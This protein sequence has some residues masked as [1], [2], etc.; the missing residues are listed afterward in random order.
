MVQMASIQW[1]SVAAMAMLTTGCA[2]MHNAQAHEGRGQGAPSDE[3]T[4]PTEQP[5]AR[6][7]YDHATPSNPACRQVKG[8]YDQTYAAAICANLYREVAAHYC[9]TDARLGETTCSNGMI[10]QH[11]VDGSTTVFRGDEYEATVTPASGTRSMLIAFDDGTRG[12]CQV[13]PWA[14]TL[15]VRADPSQRF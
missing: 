1:V 3:P 4:E 8:S 12:A 7:W 5:L 13:E 14:I 9:E 6:I 15:C 2:D 10:L 11:E